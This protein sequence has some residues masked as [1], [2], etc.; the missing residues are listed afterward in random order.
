M[1]KE[2]AGSPPDPGDAWSLFDPRYR[3]EV[4]RFE[5]LAYFALSPGISKVAY[6]GDK[7]PRQVD[8][9]RVDGPEES[10]VWFSVP[11]GRPKLAL[12]MAMRH[13]FRKLTETPGRLQKG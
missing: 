12:R 2:P 13:L 7:K 3:A 6:V 4:E 1:G 9:I 8:E 11:Q 5:T 10:L